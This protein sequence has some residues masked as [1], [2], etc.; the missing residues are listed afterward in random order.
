[1]VSV[2]LASFN[3]EKYIKEQI[4]SIL[5][6]LS[7]KD[8]LLISDDGSLDNTL[9]IIKEF[10]DPRIKLFTNNFRSVQQNFH[11]LLN[12]ANG[13]I[14]FLSDQDD[15]WERQKVFEY[16]KCFDTNPNINLVIADLV[17]INAR[18]ETIKASFY[19]SKFSK[20]LFDNFYKNNFIGCSMAIRKS[21]L[22][23]V[24]PFP[25]NVPMH[26]WWIGLC[27][28]V[29]G[30]VHFLD[31]KL[32]KYRRHETNVT[33]ESGGEIIQKIAWRINILTYL[34]KRYF[35]KFLF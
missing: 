4:R 30:N 21:L 16:L 28:I 32:T 6:Q 15:I 14:I 19:S 1:M 18:G 11:F 33:N 20:S 3:G 34:L 25:S 8:E 24:L 7:D 17:L 2:C 12:Q 31:K 22:E 10:I 29:F 9:S 5:N 35:I 23:T 27:A 13:D 26:D